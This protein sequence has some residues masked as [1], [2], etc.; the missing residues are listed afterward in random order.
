MIADDRY[1]SCPF[2]SRRGH[3]L[4]L[5]RLIRTSRN[6]VLDF[7]KDLSRNLHSSITSGKDIQYP[8]RC[9][10]FSRRNRSAQK[11]SR[12][13]RE[14]RGL[15]GPWA[16]Q[17]W[18]ILHVRSQWRRVGDQGSHAGYGSRP[19]RND[20]HVAG[21]VRGHGDRHCNMPR[22]KHDNHARGRSRPR[23]CLSSGGI[24]PNS[25]VCQS[26]A[27]GTG[28]PTRKAARG[29]EKKTQSR[30]RTHVVILRGRLY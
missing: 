20:C 10:D 23:L 15:Y 17:Q 30:G 25:D 21:Y 29:A 24:H 12:G 9:N 1:P 4:R 19:S 14:T 26:H 2:I 7:K 13:T 11:V 28:G 22:P 16:R 27:R 5:V 8:E 18:G 6:G 3:L